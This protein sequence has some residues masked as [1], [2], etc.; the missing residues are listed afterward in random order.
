M[1]SARDLHEFAALEGEDFL[2]KIVGWGPDLKS[3]DYD[4]Y[5]KYKERFPQIDDIPEVGYHY[6]GTFS[7][8]RVILLK[9]DVVIFPLWLVDREGVADDISRLEQV[10]IPSIFTD[11]WK[12][13]FENPVMSTLL[14]G[15]L[16][17]KEKR[18]KEIADFYQERVNEVESRLQRIDKPKPRVY[19]EI[20]WKGPAEYADTYGNTGWGA[21]VVKSGGMNIAEAVV[22]RMAPINP[23]YLLKVNPEVI[24]ISGSRWPET[25]DAMALGYYANPEESRQLLGA[26]T[27]R[28]G[29]N[30][31]NAVRNERVHGIFHGFCFRIYNFAAIQA[32]AKWFYPDE[33]K[34]IDPEADLREFHDKFLPV[35]YSGVWMI[36]I[37]E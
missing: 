10:G 23:E 27:E 34:D 36:S 20:G 22:E 26:F 3:A 5:L 32:F 31:L 11:Y 37:T 28:P 25:P 30:T 29:W 7:V 13:P 15:T 6:Q 24:I 17:G 16:L 1:A 19:V 8:E 18:A 4:T 35:D 2:K 12:K 9:P 33:F 21:V 14:L